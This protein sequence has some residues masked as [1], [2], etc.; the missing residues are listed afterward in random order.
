MV[1]EL[2]S[3]GIKVRLPGLVTAVLLAIG[4]FVGEWGMR[5]LK[6]LP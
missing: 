6:G 4:C 1:N 2:A 5:R 3:F